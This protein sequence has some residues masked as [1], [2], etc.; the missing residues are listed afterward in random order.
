MVL[1]LIEQVCYEVVIAESHLF[2]RAG[3]TKSRYSAKITFVPIFK[4]WLIKIENPRFA[5]RALREANRDV[6]I[7]IA[8]SS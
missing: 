1:D 8:Y 5:D 2:S 4:A 3:L 6:Y 7:N